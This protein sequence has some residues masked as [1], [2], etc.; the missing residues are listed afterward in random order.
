[1]LLP[2]KPYPSVE[3]IKTMM[4]IYDDR[5]MRIHRREDF[6]DASFIS[7]LDK[8]GYIDGLYKRVGRARLAPS[9]PSDCASS[10]KKRPRVAGASA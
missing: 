6:Y 7:E 10:K 3:G 4:E 9:S 2:A 1:V 5:E 8:S